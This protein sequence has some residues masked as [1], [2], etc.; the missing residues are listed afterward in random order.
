M[1]EKDEIAFAHRTQVARGEMIA[2][3]VPRPFALGD[4]IVIAVDIR[5]R[6]HQPELLAGHVGIGKSGHDP[7]GIRS[8][9]MELPHV[10]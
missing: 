8:Q 9:K 10:A 2:H 4:E 3:A 7:Q 6:L 5:L 1:V